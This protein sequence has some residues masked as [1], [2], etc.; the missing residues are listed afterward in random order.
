MCV[1]VLLG[2]EQGVVDVFVFGF[3]CRTTKCSVCVALLLQNGGAGQDSR[4]LEKW[5]LIQ[6]G[7]CIL[8]FDRVKKQYPRHQRKYIVIEMDEKHDM[9]TLLHFLIP[10]PTPTRQHLLIMHKSFNSINY[11]LRSSAECVQ[12]K[13][14]M[15]GSLTTR[16]PI[17]CFK[18]VFHLIFQL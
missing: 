10:T 6:C 15:F 16:G 8:N 13:I 2:V 3:G 4:H 1:C 18:I 9:C 17:L 5:F 14:F 11:S 7:R 12:R